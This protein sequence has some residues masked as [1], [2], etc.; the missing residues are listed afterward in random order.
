MVR[1]WQELFNNRR[2]SFVDLSVNPEFMK[3]GEAYGIES[4]K[5]KTKRT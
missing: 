5:I 2:Y 1:Q 4:V 3:I